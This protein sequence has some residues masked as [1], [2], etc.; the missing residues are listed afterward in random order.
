MRFLLLQVVLASVTLAAGGCFRPVNRWSFNKPPDAL[1]DEVPRSAD[2]SQ[3]IL[4]IGTFADPPAT[5]VPMGEVGLSFTRAMQQALLN[6]GVIDVWHNADLA[7][8]VDGVLHG[9]TYER[10]ERLQELHARYEHVRFVMNGTV[11]DFTHTKDVPREV[12]RWGV[13]GGFFG[14]RKEAS[15][16]SASRWS[17]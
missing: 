14:C 11:T 12:R 16:R 6:E 17:T 7:R 3:P 15:S 8:D 5:N 2:E 1:A 4:V 9:P 13:L 10:K